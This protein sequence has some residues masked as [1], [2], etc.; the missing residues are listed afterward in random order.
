VS[1]LVVSAILEPDDADAFHCVFLNRLFR[2]A[3]AGSDKT[4]A[5]VIRVIF[6]SP[7]LYNTTSKVERVKGAVSGVLRSFTYWSTSPSMTP[8]RPSVPSNRPSTPT[9]A[10]ENTLLFEKV[11]FG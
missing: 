4:G 3:Q 6:G 11:D 5:L 10:K 9:A 2:V 8:R 1:E 7:H